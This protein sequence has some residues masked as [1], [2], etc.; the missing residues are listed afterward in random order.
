MNLRTLGIVVL[1]ALISGCILKP[2]ETV[3]FQ[4]TSMLP[5]IH[6][7]DKLTIERFDPAGK[8][9]P[10]RGDVV[11]FWYPDDPSKSYIKRLIGLSGDTVEIR[12]GEVLI[13][14]RKLE[15]PYVDP[16]FKLSHASQPPV[17]VRAHYY[18]VLGD[19]RD[20]SSDSR[21]WGLV[22]EK[23]IYAKVISQ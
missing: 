10:K 6:D 21:I 11:V 20:S 23:Y 19:N 4:G 3:V 18:Y 1:A 14:G 2:K 17:L 13:N 15:E 16:K 9:N 7:G 8:F 5:G 12:E 22:P